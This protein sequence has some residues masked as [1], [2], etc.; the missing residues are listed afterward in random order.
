MKLLAFATG[1]ALAV[2]TA[3]LP[4]RAAEEKTPDG[5]L[6]HKFLS[7]DDKSKLS[8]AYTLLDICEE[9]AARDVDRYGARPTILAR[10]MAI[11]ATAVFDAWAA[12]DAKAVG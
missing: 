9:A 3:V 8:L 4:A 10:Q 2:A 5:R 12:Y 6:L 7:V 1:L 11:W